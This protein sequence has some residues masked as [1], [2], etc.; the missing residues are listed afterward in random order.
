MGLF[1]IDEEVLQSEYMR[2]VHESD[3]NISKAEKDRDLEKAVCYFAETRGCSYDEAWSI[4]ANAGKRLSKSED[5]GE[6]KRSSISE[7]Y[8]YRRNSSSEDSSYKATAKLWYGIIIASMVLVTLW[9]LPIFFSEAGTYPK[10]YDGAY[11]VTWII[12]FIAYFAVKIWCG[13]K[14]D[15]HKR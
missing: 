9:Y 6:S 8:N 13:H 2:A 12:L 10:W 7:T 11:I 3:W 4:A 15:E 14:E 1:D 5:D